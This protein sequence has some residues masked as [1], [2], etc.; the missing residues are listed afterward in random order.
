MVLLEHRVG[1]PC[2]KVGY[3]KM[4]HSCRTVR[5]QLS[6]S[7]RTTVLTL[8]LERLNR[9]LAARLSELDSRLFMLVQEQ[10]GPDT[11]HL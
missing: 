8:R 5:R 9:V 4:P 10:Q 2:V 6:C 3:G 1:R 7:S 11:F